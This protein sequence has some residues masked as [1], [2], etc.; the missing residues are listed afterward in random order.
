MTQ[1]HSLPIRN[2]ASAAAA[3]SGHDKPRPRESGP[4]RASCT[5]SLQELAAREDEAEEVTENSTP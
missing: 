1:N 5:R 4:T 3:W 2:R